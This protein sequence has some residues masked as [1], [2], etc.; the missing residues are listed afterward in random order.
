M[1]RW[2]CTG[3]G[4]QRMDTSIRAPVT[5]CSCI[6]KPCHSYLTP[7]RQVKVRHQKGAL[8]PKSVKVCAAAASGPLQ[9]GA[10]ASSADPPEHG[11]R[12]VCGETVKI[13]GES[14]M[15]QTAQPETINV[16]ELMQE[17]DEA[18]A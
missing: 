18:F 5:I 9:S 8:S 13:I 11:Y 16:V 2:Q 7:K 6:S 14:L 3:Y 12:E 10:S 15:K 4:A 1:H 17:C